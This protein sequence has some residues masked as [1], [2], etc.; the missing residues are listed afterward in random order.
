MI[1]ADVLK[2]NNYI[3]VDVNIKGFGLAVFTLEKVH[4]EFLDMFPHRPEE[5]H[6]TNMT[7]I[8][9]KSCIAVMLLIKELVN[10]D[11]KIIFVIEDPTAMGS[12]YTKKDGT[13]VTAWQTASI[14][15]KLTGMLAVIAV[16]N[17]Y[18]LYTPSSVIWKKRVLG[19]GDAKKPAIQSEMYKIIYGRASR[20]GG[21]IENHHVAD[22]AALA[23]YGYKEDRYGRQETNTST[24]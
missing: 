14:L 2:D 19:K 17:N 24:T 18:K 20:D 5:Y 22:G 1:Q 6:L 10:P 21:S 16:Q 8:W 23:Y 12:I 15:D 11:R 13:I 9:A 3:G 4:L 7:T